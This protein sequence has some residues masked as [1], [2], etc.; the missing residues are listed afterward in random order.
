M[1]ELDGQEEALS[2]GLPTF[3]Y[4]EVVMAHGGGGRLSRDL[5][6]QVFLP[7]LGVEFEVA[8]RDSAVM[9]V[10]G[11]RLA[12]STDS[13]VVQPLF[14]PGGSI[15]ELA[16]NGTVNDL[17][18]SGA[19]PLAL[20]VAF[21]VEEGMPIE[22]LREVARRLGQAAREAGVAVLTGDT[23]VIE[24]RGSSGDQAGLYLNT[25]GIGLVPEGIE[26]GA[27]R[28]TPGDVV[29]LS[30]PIGLHGVAVMAKRAGLEFETLVSSDTAPLAGLVA[31][32]LKA[33]RDI[34]VLR[35]PTRG[36]LAATLCEIAQAAK[37]GIEY[38]ESVLPI[39]PEV[40]AACAF[41]GLD[42]TE[43]AN[44]GKLVAVVPPGSSDDVLAAMASHPL[45][46]DAVIVGRVTDAHPG[47]VVA[48]TALGVTR[49][50][51][52]PLGEALPRIC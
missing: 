30:G 23:K 28:A 49:V 13:Y 39:P 7:A 32:M 27:S 46:R 14:F 45:G 16:V 19:K 34:H 3:G 48:R 33:N 6:E 11:T 36:G 41:L 15:G 8:Q 42:P 51:D 52:M 10:G 22:T 5:I 29:I 50:V 26:I 37:V 21:V 44:E 24:R 2:C 31:E 1:S 18:M 35:D 9:E 17:A 43:V 47:M 20:S 12:F 25:A 4:E 38:E 40:E